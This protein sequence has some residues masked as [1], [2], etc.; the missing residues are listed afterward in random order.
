[1]QISCNA[2]GLESEQKVTKE[3][4]VSLE[5]PQGFKGVEALNVYK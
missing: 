5:G 1:M 2:D 4:E 3:C